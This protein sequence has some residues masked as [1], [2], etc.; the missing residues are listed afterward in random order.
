VV[1][2]VSR[3]GDGGVDV[4]GSGQLDVADRFFGVRGDDSELLGVGGLAPL[5]A[6]EQFVISPVAGGFCNRA[7]PRGLGA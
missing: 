6:D 1:E 7:L 2:G 3:G 5:T 4:L